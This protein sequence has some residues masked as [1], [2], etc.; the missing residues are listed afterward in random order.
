MN[1]EELKAITQQLADVELPPAPD[2]QPLIIAAVAII[3]ALLVAVVVIYL[4]SRRKDSNNVSDRNRDAPHQLQLL[5]QAWQKKEID[6]HDAAYR[7]ATLLRLGLGLNQLGDM[8]PPSL[9]G[10][11]QQ[12]R[13]LLQQLAQLRYRPHAGEEEKKE[14]TTEIFIQVEQWLKRG[15]APC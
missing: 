7:L 9:Q 15:E 14:L 6:D 8:P 5:Q 13:Q 12:W 4:R 11:Q 3:I 2:W 1:S 10:D